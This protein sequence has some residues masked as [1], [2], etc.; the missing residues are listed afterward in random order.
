MV[1]ASG[2][3]APFDR[4]AAKAVGQLD[5]EGLEVLVSRNLVLFDQKEERFRLHDLF[6]DLARDGFSEE[7]RVR[8]RQ[9]PR[10]AFSKCLVHGRRKAQRDKEGFFDGLRLFDRERAHIEAGKLGPPRTRKTV[11]K[12]C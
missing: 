4:P 11:T 3:P 6:R 5:A 10:R 2:V 7:K 9:A 12:R 1:L 8:R